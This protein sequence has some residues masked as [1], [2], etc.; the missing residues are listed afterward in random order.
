M[1]LRSGAHAI[2]EKPL[3]L[4]PWNLDALAEM[5]KE[6]DKKVNTILQ[7]RLHPSIIALKE[8]I[9][10]EDSSKIHDVDLTYL[11]SRGELVLY[12]LEGRR[13]KIGRNS[14]KHW[15]SLL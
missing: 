2:C 13:N 14:L 10:K 3:V 6:Y 12:L 4:N 11:T 15:Y 8:R 7:L 5:E 1:A 9:D